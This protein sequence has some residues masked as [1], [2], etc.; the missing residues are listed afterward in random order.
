MCTP[1]IFMCTPFYMFALVCVVFR[2]LSQ[3]QQN[4]TS[5]Y[6]L[7]EEKESPINYIGDDIPLTRGC[8]HLSLFFFHDAVMFSEMWHID[9]GLYFL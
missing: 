8:F 3:Q 5:F 1:V 2:V 4:I 6:E 7:S 9:Y